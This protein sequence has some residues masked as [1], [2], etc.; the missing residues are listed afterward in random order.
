MGCS[1][2]RWFPETVLLTVG[3]ALAGHLLQYTRE[4]LTQVPWRER[5]GSV[6]ASLGGNGDSLSGPMCPS[7]QGVGAPS[8]DPPGVSVL[9]LLMPS[10]GEGGKPGSLLEGPCLSELAHSSPPLPPPSIRLS[11][12][13]RFLTICHVEAPGPEEASW[14]SACAGGSRTCTLFSS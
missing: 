6:Q 10:Q 14:S 12:G 3:S 1:G 7:C 13:L 4:Q 5:Q 11:A 8:W 2:D 9:S